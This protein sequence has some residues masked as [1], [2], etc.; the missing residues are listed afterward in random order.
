MGT[1]P[2]DLRQRTK[3]FALRI[4]TLFRALPRNQESRVLGL[5]VLRS[6]TSVGANYR[7]AHRSRSNAEYVSKLGIS[8]QELE[9]TRYWIELLAD[10]G[11]VPTKRVT[12]LLTEAGELTAIMIAMCKTAGGRARRENPVDD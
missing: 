5:Q 8:L 3:E 12:G 2:I 11:I 7:E 1:P 9:E 6:G 4:I 10:A